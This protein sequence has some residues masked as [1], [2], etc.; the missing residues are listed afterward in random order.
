MTRTAWLLLTYLTFPAAALA[1]SDDLHLF[2]YSQNSFEHTYDSASS[3]HANTFRLQQLNVFLQK[4]L[5]PAWTSFVSFEMLNSYSSFRRWGAFN[6]DEA[7]VKF[8]SSKELNLK[9]GL[10]IP[11]FNNLNEIKNRTPLLPYIVRPFVYETAF[12]EIVGLEWYVPERAFVS[13]YGFFPR[14]SSKWDYAVYLGNSPNIADNPAVDQTGSDTT[15]TFLIGTRIGLRRGNTK[16]GIS[17]TRDRT[18]RLQPAA[19]ELGF[20]ASDLEEVRRLRIGGDFS[21]HLGD[22]AIEA[23]GIA[24]R[25]DHDVTGFESRLNFYYATV[26]YRFTEPLLAFV[27]YWYA[28]TELSGSGTEELSIPNVGAAYHL[29]DRIVL[30]AQV[31]QAEI[32]DVDEQHVRVSQDLDFYSVAVSAFF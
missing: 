3:R 8:R 28:D 19:E 24:V 2:G 23:E 4:P 11:V 25:F 16:V 6:L 31:A 29:S 30:K 22:V 21:A 15:A 14:G 12:Q 10:Q 20:S 13:A 32:T 5:A 9:F 7:W 27:S 17:L 1:E 26:S 18:S